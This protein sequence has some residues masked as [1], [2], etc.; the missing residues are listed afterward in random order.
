MRA[1]PNCTCLL[2]C[3][4]TGTSIALADLTFR[5]ITQAPQGA[6]ALFSLGASNS[7]LYPFA[8]QP[9]VAFDDYRTDL[10]N[11]TGSVLVAA[12]RPL[13]ML[14]YADTDDVL[15]TAVLTGT[16]LVN[17]IQVSQCGPPHPC[18]LYKIQQDAIQL[19]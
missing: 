13:A 10:Q 11:S 2:A 5:L 16:P 6:A 7:Q 18:F 3:R 4:Y 9:Q 19:Y 12:V 17:A 14:A 1:C 15:N 8:D